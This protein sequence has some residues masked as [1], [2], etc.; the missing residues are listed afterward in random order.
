MHKLD[1]FAGAGAVH[2]VKYILGSNYSKITRFLWTIALLL[3]ICG[4]FFYIRIAYQKLMFQP[5]LVIKVTDRN[6]SDFPA[7]AVTICSNLFARNNT[8]SISDFYITTTRKKRLNFLK[9]TF[10]VNLT[11]EQCAC[12]T[13]NIHWCQPNLSTQVMKYCT[14]PR[15]EK[16]NVLD[17]IDGSA[18]LTSDAFLMCSDSRCDDRIKRVFTD[19]GI[20][21][22]V[23][24]L[25]YSSLFNTEIIHEDFKE[26]FLRTEMNSDREELSKWSPESGYS[27]PDQTYPQRANL[28]MLNFS[29]IPILSAIDKDNVCAMHNFRIILHKPNEIATPFHEVVFLNYNEVS[30]IILIA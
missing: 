16:I 28:N 8:A 1:K 20:C 15:L 14:D 18:H 27:S 23:N 7:P 5:E 2:G 6:F 22:T 9:Y 24:L 17:Y 4:F 11:V 13:A 12:L 26:F 25:S 19:S 21:Y 29:F 30:L 10:E 3:S